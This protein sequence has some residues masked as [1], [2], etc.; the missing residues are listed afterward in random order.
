MSHPGLCSTHPEVYCQILQEDSTFVCAKCASFELEKDINSLTRH[1]SPWNQSAF[2]ERK[3][4]FAKL[5]EKI[6]LKR[7]TELAKKSDELFKQN[8]RKNDFRSA[9]E[10]LRMSKKDMDILMYN[11]N[12]KKKDLLS[13]VRARKNSNFRNLLGKFIKF[14]EVDVGKILR[15]STHGSSAEKDSNDETRAIRKR[16]QLFEKPQT[17]V[18]ERDLLSTLLKDDSGVDMDEETQDFLLMSMSNFLFLEQDM[19]DNSKM[20]HL[21]R[22]FKREVHEPGETIITEG[23]PGSRL[24]ILDQGT[25]EIFINNDF[26]REMSRGAI[27]GELALLYDAPRSATV[28]C[29]SNGEKVV[30]WSLNRGIFK[31]IQIESSSVVQ[32]Q[33]SKWLINC[34]DLAVLGAVDLQRLV[35]SLQLIELRADSKVYI[36]EELS[37]EV[38]IVEKG[39]VSIYATEALAHKEIEEIDATLGII[40]PSGRPRYVFEENSMYA[41]TLVAEAIRNGR[42]PPKI[43]A[44]H[45]CDVMEGCIL[46]IDILRGKAGLPHAWEWVSSTSGEGKGALVP[47]TAVAGSDVNILVFNVETFE[48]LIG[49]V[50]DTFQSSVFSLKKA[51]IQRQERNEIVSLNCRKFDVAQFTIKHILGSGSFGY[52][53]Y[54]EYTEKE[55]APKRFSFKNFTEGRNSARISKDSSRS[56]SAIGSRDEDD[57]PAGYALKLFSKNEVVATGQVEQIINEKRIL[58]SLRNRFILRLFGT[59]QSSNHLYIVTEVLDCGDLWELLYI[60][61]PNPRNSLPPD[62]ITFY[63]AS[64]ILGLDYMHEKGFAHRDIKPENIMLDVRGYLRI[65]DFGFCKAIPYTETLPGGKERVMAKSFTLCGTP[66]K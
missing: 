40:R 22:A 51:A 26:I 52:V 13:E 38:V 35:S 37:N 63:A 42:K 39:F 20:K 46:G 30:L 28:K 24:Y 19:K 48:R 43:P 29:K 4:E 32:M 5:Y 57:K 2:N 56:S 59:T 47:F 17:N 18:D 58:S 60:K 34:N 64:I 44:V 23:E 7:K 15:K 33:R 31:Q 9:I 61:N 27:F 16:I 12:N 8:P 25:V 14:D 6:N 3:A 54:A 21:L 65:I 11:Y 50:S 55:A 66:G 45:V 62:L 10:D 41:S 49:P 53:A 36:M 1:N